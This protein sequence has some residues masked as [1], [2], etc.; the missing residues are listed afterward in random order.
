MK[1]TID[2]RTKEEYTRPLYVGDDI[3]EI[4]RM[5]TKVKYIFG[6]DDS[7]RRRLMDA[8]VKLNDLIKRLMKNTV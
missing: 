1:I 5:L 6:D 7:Q 4:I 8:K 3:D 2:N